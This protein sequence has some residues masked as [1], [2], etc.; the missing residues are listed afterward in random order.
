ML[1]GIC[2]LIAAKSLE[3]SHLCTVRIYLMFNFILKHK[4]LM[5]QSGIV[6]HKN[7]LLFLNW[8]S[9]LLHRLFSLCFKTISPLDVG[10][11]RGLVAIYVFWCWYS[12]QD[13]REVLCIQPFIFGE[14]VEII[15]HYKLSIVFLKLHHN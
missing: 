13:K 9:Q 4:F 12:T 14:K 15:W 10:I 1:W 3:R 8:L 7:N 6:S 2:C 5:Q 11:L